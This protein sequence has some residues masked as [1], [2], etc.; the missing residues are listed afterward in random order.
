MKRKLKKEELKQ[1]VKL[2][3]QLIE[4]YDKRVKYLTSKV[5]LPY[6]EIFTILTLII[7]LKIKISKI[8]K[9]D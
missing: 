3:S 9:A 8:Q 6:F 5:R 1:V 4:L 2:Q 7:A